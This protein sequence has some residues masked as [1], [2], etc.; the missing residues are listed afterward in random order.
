VAEKQL[1]TAEVEQLERRLLDSYANLIAVVKGELDKLTRAYDVVRDRVAELNTTIRRVSISNIERIELQVQESQLV[2]AIRQTSRLQLDLFGPAS[3]DLPVEAAE[4]Q[5]E[6]FVVRTL[7]AHGKEL[8]LDDLFQLEFKV[9]FAT[10]G[11]QRSVADIHAFESNGTAVGV[12]IVVYLGLIKL[13]QG[14]R[15]G[16]SARVPFF[17][18]E[19]GSLSSNNVRQ[20]IAYC[21]DHN[22][23]PIFASPTIRS[24]IPHSYILQRDGE[25]SRLVNEVILTDGVSVDEVTSVDQA[26]AA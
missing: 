15:R 10:T 26:S 17:L 25:R 14:S 22:F 21:A 8:S 2:E 13:L 12:K 1:L 24:D 16:T 23:L 4:Q 20:I 6:E 3:G 7:R 5:I 19:V 11:E 9:T 18:D